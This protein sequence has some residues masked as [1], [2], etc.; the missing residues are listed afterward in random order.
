MR[1]KI[2][3]KNLLSNSSCKRLWE[4]DHPPK[5]LGCQSGVWKASGSMLDGPYVLSANGSLGVWKLCTLGYTSG[6]TK[7]LTYSNGNWYADIDGTQLVD[8]YK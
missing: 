2:S 7:Q 3:R 8:C 4:Q 5:G 6:N 1:G